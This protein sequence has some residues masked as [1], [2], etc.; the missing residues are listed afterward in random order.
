M[1]TRRSP[2][3]ARPSMIT[4]HRDYT[5]AVAVQQITAMACACYE[6]GVY[7]RDANG[8]R[9]A[10]L[11]RSWDADTLLRSID[12]L[13]F[14]NSH[15]CDVYIRPAGSPHHLSL[16]DDL[17][18]QAVAEM[19]NTGFEP[20]AIVETSSNNFQAWLKHPEPLDRETSTAAARG[21]AERFGG[22]RGAA[23]WRH[24]GRLAGVTNR[25]L[26]YQNVITGLYP[27]VRLVEASG[28]RYSEGERFIAEV[29]S[30]VEE[31][32]E[33]QK[34][35]CCR[36]LARRRTTAGL[37]PIEAFRG[38]PRY[39]GDG[40]RCDLAYAVY[41]LAHGV[42]AAQ[43]EAAIRSRDLSHRGSDR[44]QNDYVQRTLRKA[45]ERVG[46]ER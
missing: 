13:K 34:R 15:G 26:R 2:T 20:A 23:D 1:A 29:K 37:K 17:T 3:E 43:V 41:A 42:S 19:R 40:K 18:A 38:D 9:G 45:M 21:L 14:R 44:R 46:L 16:I 27:F 6:I 30:T 28:Q 33:R 4:T 8:G 25:K 10:M 24:F 39:E 12:W 22:D 36:Y 35:L 7:W 32:R 5:T 31:T 11:L